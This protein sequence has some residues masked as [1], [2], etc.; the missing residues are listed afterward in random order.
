MRF[1][2]GMPYLQCIERR[3]PVIFRAEDGTSVVSIS[4]TVRLYRIP[5]P[6]FSLRQERDGALLFRTRCDP[7]TES[8]IRAALRELF[9]ALPLE[10]EQV[11]WEEAWRGKSTQYASDNEVTA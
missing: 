9:G 8:I 6:F 4:V 11:P 1:D 5:L 7:A 10:I 2:A 3:R